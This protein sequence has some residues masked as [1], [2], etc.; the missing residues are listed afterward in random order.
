MADMDL[1]VYQVRNK[2][3]NAETYMSE[4]EISSSDDPAAWEEDQTPV[5]ESRPK[6]FLS[7]N[8]Q[9]AVELALAQGNAARCQE[10]KVPLTRS[11]TIC[12]CSSRPA[13]TRR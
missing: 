3:T 13:S 1:V 4:E 11:P 10:L 5:P 7:V 8:G 9:R 6:Y 2:Q 12:W